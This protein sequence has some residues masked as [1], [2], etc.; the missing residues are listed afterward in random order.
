M[1]TLSFLP[2]LVV[3]V[4]CSGAAKPTQPGAQW[5]TLQRVGDVKAESQIGNPSVFYYRFK[6]TVETTEVRY[7]L[8]CVA[9]PDRHELFGLLPQVGKSVQIRT[10]KDG[11]WLSFVDYA[12]GCS[13]DGAEST[14]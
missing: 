4:G 12:L 14:H 11:S 10:Y 8:D 9:S 7:S 5:A 1:K 6:A 3:L 2:L 13:V